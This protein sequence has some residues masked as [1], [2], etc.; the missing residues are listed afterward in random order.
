[1][2]LEYQQGWYKLTYKSGLVQYT[3]KLATA[4]RLAKT[5]RN[6]N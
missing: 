5:W 3:D 2:K 6:L 1:M 4:F